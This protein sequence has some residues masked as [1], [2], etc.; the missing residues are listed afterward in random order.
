MKLII[1]SN[2]KGKIREYKQILEP[3]GFEVL[4]QSEAGIDLEAE[5]TGTT[6]AENSAI[7]AR[8]IY[9]MT[10]CAVLADDSGLSVDA[11]GGEP[12]VYS[13][14]YEGIESSEGRSLRILEK[15]KDVPEEQR[16]ASFIC[17]IHMILSDG[18]EITVEG[19]C[20]GRIG[21]EQLGTNGFGYDP[22]FMYGDRSFAEIPSEEKNRVSHRAAAL[23]KLIENLKEL[24][25][26]D[27]TKAE[28]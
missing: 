13:A 8:A 26:Y 6:F 28:G 2:N 18:R 20:T 7:K 27:N 17:C 3:M 1:A 11:L 15:L 22:I 12:G 4:S 14:R 16:G 5:E 23:E 21:Y 19:R 25:I 9:G 24:D 10:K